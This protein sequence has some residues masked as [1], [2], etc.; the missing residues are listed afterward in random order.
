MPT[1]ISETGSASFLLSFSS[2][3]TLSLPETG[4]ESPSGILDYKMRI[5]FPEKDASSCN[6]L[7]VSAK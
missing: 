5:A 1:G 2:A 4:L 7:A 6:K 3:A